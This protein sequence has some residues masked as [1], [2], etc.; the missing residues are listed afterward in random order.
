MASTPTNLTIPIDPELKAQAKAL[1]DELGLSL[2]GACNIFLR[3]AV[4]EGRIPFEITL[5]S[6]AGKNGAQSESEK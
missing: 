2:S 3:Q 4:R 5:N 6:P 1:F